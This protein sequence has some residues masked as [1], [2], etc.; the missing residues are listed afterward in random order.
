MEFVTA[1]A[2]IFGVLSTALLILR[3]VGLITYTGSVLELRDNLNGVERVF[4]LSVPTVTAIICWTW[5][6]TS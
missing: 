2:W 3:V 1:L 5:V 6:L 4:P